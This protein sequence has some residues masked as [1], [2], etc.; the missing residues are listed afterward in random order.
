MDDDTED[1][2]EAEWFKLRTITDITD[3]KYSV[4]NLER[5]KKHEFVVTA[6]NRHGEGLKKN[7][8]SVKVSKGKR[9][10]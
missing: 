5:G 10:E 1:G 2:A 9:L 8:V 7:V 4:E 3:C 6:T